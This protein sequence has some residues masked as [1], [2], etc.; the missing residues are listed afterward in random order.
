[1]RVLPGETATAV[2]LVA[3]SGAV[4]AVPEGHI[5]AHAAPALYTDEMY[6]ALEARN[7]RLMTQITAMQS[8]L[9][10]KDDTI[11]ALQR[12]VAQLQ[13]QLGGANVFAWPYST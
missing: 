3:S 7:M 6:I 9:D 5:A 12:Q 2:Q 8:A 13:T 4:Y 1:M 10:A 11:D